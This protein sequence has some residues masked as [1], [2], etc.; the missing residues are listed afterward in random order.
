MAIGAAVMAAQKSGQ[1]LASALPASS[2]TVDMLASPKLEPL[3]RMACHSQLLLRTCDDH[4]R[5]PAL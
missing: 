4:N 2:L 1:A 5:L 3:Q